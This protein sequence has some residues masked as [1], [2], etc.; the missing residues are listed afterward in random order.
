MADKF[1]RREV[2]IRRVEYVVCPPDPK[3]EGDDY[4]RYENDR[5]EVMQVISAEM[6][7]SEPHDLRV[8]ELPEETIISFETQRIVLPRSLRSST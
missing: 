2:A 4:D 1:P 7:G 8:I 3:A 6:N 5:L